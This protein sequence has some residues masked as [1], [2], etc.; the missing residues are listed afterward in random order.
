[1]FS[2]NLLAAQMKTLPRECINHII[3]Y[4]YSP[5][6]PELTFEIRENYKKM[7][8]FKIYFDRVNSL[9]LYG[10]QFMQEYLY[11]MILHPSIY[12]ELSHKVMEYKSWFSHRYAYVLIYRHMNI[13]DHTKKSINLYKKESIHKF[14]KMSFDQINNILYSLDRLVLKSWYVNN[15]GLPPFPWMYEAAPAPAPARKILL[16][17]YSKLVQIFT[18]G[19]AA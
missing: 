7:Q 10:N 17:K 19:I 9:S 15:T 18:H 2:T 8:I 11:N 5:Q 1:M 12:V 3:G 4:T 16:P 6:P 13:D 14:N